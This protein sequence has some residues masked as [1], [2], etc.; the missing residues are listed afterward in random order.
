[1]SWICLSS[2]LMSIE[3]SDPSLEYYLIICI[4]CCKTDHNNN[5]YYINLLFALYVSWVIKWLYAELLCFDL[6][7]VFGLWSSHFLCIR[8]KIRSH[9]HMNALSNMYIENSSAKKVAWNN[10]SIASK[11]VFGKCLS[12]YQNIVVSSLMI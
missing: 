3:R 8:N 2:N 1:M 9:Q 10:Y 11:Y 12:N 4:W 6:V 5:R 7:F